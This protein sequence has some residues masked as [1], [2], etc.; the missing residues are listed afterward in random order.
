MKAKMLCGLVKTRLTPRRRLSASGI[1]ASE[2]PCSG[3]LWALCR[4]KRQ[5]AFFLRT[6]RISYSCFS[7]TSR[8]RPVWQLQSGI[9]RAIRP[10]D[11]NVDANTMAAALFLRVSYARFTRMARINST[12]PYYICSSIALSSPGDTKRRFRRRPVI[13]SRSPSLTSR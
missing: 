9:G 13:S 12:L 10:P 3:R 8:I 2:T 5:R 4:P 1:R 6:P 11:L 7:R